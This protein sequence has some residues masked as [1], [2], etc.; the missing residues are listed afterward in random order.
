[1]GSAAVV[2]TWDSSREQGVWFKPS[3]C[4]LQTALSVWVSGRG[5]GQKNDSRLVHWS[6]P[7][8]A[9]LCEVTILGVRPGSVL[10]PL[11]S[12]TCLL[13][14]RSGPMP[15]SVALSF[16]VHHL[17]SREVFGLALP[18]ATEIVYHC[19]MWILIS[20]RCLDFLSYKAVL[21]SINCF[22]NE[23]SCT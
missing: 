7:I 22:P 16:P 10:C 4:I 21:S 9:L 11:Y 13:P 17:Y 3:F 15:F 23:V 14:G 8:T 2:N 1:M 12:C 6:L 5:F 20:Q 18:L 19:L